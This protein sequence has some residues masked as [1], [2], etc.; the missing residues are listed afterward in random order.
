MGSPPGAGPPGKA[1]GAGAASARGQCGARPGE[2][3]GS[4]SA[5]ISGSGHLET[6]GALSAC[7]AT[8][9]NLTAAF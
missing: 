8:L 6:Q 5:L 1:W 7:C 4:R 3:L 9:C 2:A